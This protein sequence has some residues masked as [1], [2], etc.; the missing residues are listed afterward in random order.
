MIK[1]KAMET[2]TLIMKYLTRGSICFGLLALI[3]T[4]FYFQQSVEA[5]FETAI[6]SQNI[7]EINIQQSITQNITTED[8]LNNNLETTN[9]KANLTAGLTKNL[10]DKTVDNS[11]ISENSSEMV[12][13]A[14]AFRSTA[15]CLKGKTASGRSVRR[16]IVAADTRI[17]PLGTRI[18]LDAGKYSGTYIVADTGGRIKGRVLDIWVPSC[19]EA[20]RWGRRN[21][22]VTVLG[23]RS[24]RK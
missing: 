6:N 17:L 4:F 13:E 8:A 12:S 11:E 9:I 1:Y 18:R 20:R 15:Y 22:K 3:M 16:G 14:R 21:I 7:K 19:A 10:D 5:A 23:K 24:K 2:E